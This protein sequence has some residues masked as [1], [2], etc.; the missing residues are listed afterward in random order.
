[1]KPCPASI[2]LRRL[3]KFG[4]CLGILAAGMGPALGATPAPELQQRLTGIVVTSVLR[5]AMFSAAGNT[6]VLHEGEQIE[7]WTL[8]SI[9]PHAVTLEADGA[10]MTLAP[11]GLPP[12]S[13]EPVPTEQP[14]A[15]AR[16]V[17]QALERQQREQADAEVELTQATARMM[18]R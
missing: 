13:A 14:G 1:M 16:Q 6:R 10:S 11:A 5:E 18:Q 2:R 4:L 3:A 12:G 9:G 7:G 8:T 17:A 15:R